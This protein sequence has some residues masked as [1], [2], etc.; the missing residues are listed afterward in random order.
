MYPCTS[1]SYTY[2]WHVRRTMNTTNIWQFAQDW[3][4]FHWKFSNCMIKPGNQVE[5]SFVDVREL[6]TISIN[7]KFNRAS[8]LKVSDEL[9]Q[10]NCLS[11]MRNIYCTCAQLLLI[12]SKQ[13]TRTIQWKRVYHNLEAILHFIARNFLFFSRLEKLKGR[14]C[15]DDIIAQYIIIL[16]D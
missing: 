11:N 14:P 1:K 6:W 10:N 2:A 13:S 9:H 4:Y 5:N 16:T 8:L 3:H 15:I 12:K 7:Y